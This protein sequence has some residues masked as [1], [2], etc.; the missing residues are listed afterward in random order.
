MNA[1]NQ[2]VRRP[3]KPDDS[4]ANR[5]CLSLCICRVTSAVINN[6]GCIYVSV[7]ERPAVPSTFLLVRVS[8]K[9]TRKSTV[10]RNKQ[11]PT[12]SKRTNELRADKWAFNRLPPRVTNPSN[13][14]TERRKKAL[15]G[16]LPRGI[17]IHAD[18]ERGQNAPRPIAGSDSSPTAPK[19]GGSKHRNKLP[20]RSPPPHPPHG[21][22]GRPRAL[23][24]AECFLERTPRHPNSSS[25]PTRAR[26]G[27]LRQGRKCSIFYVTYK[28]PTRGI[29]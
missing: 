15:G 19:R 17:I 16:A 5:R 3:S 25:P 8:S 4:C 26:R 11:N 27:V 28:R 23:V 7:K 18:G 6:I 9:E 14:R 29:D 24:H 13:E 20:G 1:M 12:S 2:H 21:K 10:T 22:E